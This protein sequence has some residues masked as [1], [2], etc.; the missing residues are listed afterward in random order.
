MLSLIDLRAR[1]AAGTL[2]PS[3]AIDLCRSAIAAREPELHALVA[4]DDAPVIAESGPLAGIA[5]GVKDIIDSAGLPTRMGSSI[6][7]GWRP[8]A[9]AAVVAQLKRL[10]AVALAKTTTTAFASSDPTATVN[11]HDPG[12]TPGGSSAGSAAAVGAGLL[13][14]GLGTQ[15]AGSVIR[16]ASYCGCAAVKP[17]FRL[18]PTVGVKTYSWALDTVGLFAAGVADVAMALAL[19]TGRPEIAGAEAGSGP[20]IGLVRQDFAEAPEPEAE[21]ALARARQAAEGAGARVTDLA[22][23]PELAQ[24]WERHRIIQN[25]E[26]RLA[27]AWEYDTQADALP[28]LVRAHLDAGAAITPAQYDDARRHGHHARRVLKGL[29]ADYDAILTFSAPGPAPATLASTGDPRFNQLWTLMGVPCVNVPV[30]GSRL[31]V[32]VQVI[33]RFGDDGRA[34][35]VARMIEAALRG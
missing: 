13:P 3:G 11:P 22:L 23:P 35:A 24:A 18:I 9:D 15:T 30:P 14:L 34:L 4:L 29:F 21:A 5:V 7:D 10:G 12:H 20:R 2:T 17:S 8:R 32:G 31:P 28:P 25:Y 16:P 26:G 27:L 19:V 33:G 6:Y 1:I